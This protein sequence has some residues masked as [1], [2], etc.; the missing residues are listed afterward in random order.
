MNDYINTL[1]DCPRCIG[2]RLL[3]D[4]RVENNFCINCGYQHEKAERIYRPRVKATK[5]ISDNEWLKKQ[6]LKEE[7]S[8]AIP[9]IATQTY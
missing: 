8:W 2:G 7:L 9:K 4:H 6:A 1:L 5:L 3:P